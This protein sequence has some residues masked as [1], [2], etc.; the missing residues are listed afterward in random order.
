MLEAL[1]QQYGL[2]RSDLDEVALRLAETQSAGGEA[3]ARE[4][5][6]RRV[7]RMAATNRELRRVGLRP[8]CLE[9]DAA[10]TAAEEEKR[11]RRATEMAR[12]LTD[13]EHEA[14]QAVGITPAVYELT[15]RGEY[16][17]VLGLRL[18]ARA[19]NAARLMCRTK[20]AIAYGDD[21]EAARAYLRSRLRAY[22]ERLLAPK[23]K[24]K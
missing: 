22:T 17:T 21:E 3:S 19:Y 7:V 24:I 5:A 2:V 12:A 6:L 15:L 13:E 9:Q 20:R 1:L 11:V 10:E 16:G 4:A 8:L 18:N 23:K 14:I